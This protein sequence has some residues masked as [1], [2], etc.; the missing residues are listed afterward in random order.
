MTT[1]LPANEDYA[2]AILSIFG[3]RGVGPG[4]TLSEKL[5]S[6]TFQA[7]RMGR[8]VDYRDALQYAV[9]RKWLTL[10]LDMLRLTPAGYAQI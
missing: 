10:Q 8:P 3:A 5:V 4:Q 9:D 1:A 6:D 2:K 7:R